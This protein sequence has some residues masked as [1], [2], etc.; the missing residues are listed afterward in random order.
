MDSPDDLLLSESVCRQLGIIQYHSEVRPVRESQ[1][2]EPSKPASSGTVP[3][4]KVSLVRSV[5]L[6][7]HQS[8]V[9]Q[10]QCAQV[11][12]SCLVEQSEAFSQETGI[13]LEPT[14]MESD[15]RGIASIVLSNTNGYSCHADAGEIVGV[16]H[17]VSVVEPG[18]EGTD[19]SDWP[20]CQPASTLSVMSQS[21]RL[22][23]LRETVGRPDLLD[24]EQSRKL[25]MLL[26]DYHS[27]FS[28]E[29]GER[30]ETHLVE[31]E[32]CTGDASPRRV[33]ARRMPLAVRQ[34]VSRQ[35]Q[36][37]QDEGIIQPSNS[38]WAIPL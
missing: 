2:M 19:G 23:L 29:E 28:V 27:A 38:P 13:H 26:E 18:E 7:P 15:R 24:T 32:I 21:E 5:H 4:V 30:G 36:K 31:M 33:A 22:S 17:S 14:L 3:L 37:M 8:I 34:E 6:L 20:V 12:V 25:H 11:N 1:K 35:L 10:V 9:A 16:S